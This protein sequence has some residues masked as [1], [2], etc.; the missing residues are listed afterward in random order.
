VV[1]LDFWGKWCLPC[2]K[3]LPRVEALHKKYKDRGLVVI[4]VHSAQGSTD[5]E[6]FLQKNGVTFP[7]A[8]DNGDS[9]TRYTVMGWPTYFLINKTG[10]VVWGF[11]N[12]LPTESQID[13]LLR[14][15]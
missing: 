15:K 7:T 11:S 1:L 10:N 5:V 4:G 12:E 2:V 9:A 14:E 3:K 13:K 8:I 6:K